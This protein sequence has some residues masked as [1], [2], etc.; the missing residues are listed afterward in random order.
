MGLFLFTINCGI[1]RYPVTLPVM[2]A[3]FVGVLYWECPACGSI[4]RTTMNAMT[5]VLQCGTCSAIFVHGVTLWK[6]PSGPHS[7]PRDTLMI[8]ENFPNKRLA[9]RNYCEDCGKT[10][11]E[12]EKL[13][14]AL[15]RA[16]NT[17]SD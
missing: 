8:G 3:R 12:K 15:Q 9:N 6:K 5:E 10:L 7:I 4:K 17:H 13:P 11:F 1:A 2:F 16:K 14:T